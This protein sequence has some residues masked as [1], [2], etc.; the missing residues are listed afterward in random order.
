MRSSVHWIPCFGWVTAI[1]GSRLGVGVKVLQGIK[2]LLGVKWFE[3]V[4]LLLGVKSRGR[5]TPGV[6][7][8]PGYL[9]PGIA[10]TSFGYDVLLVANECS[11][12][13]GNLDIENG[14]L[15][16]DALGTGDSADLTCNNGFQGSTTITVICDEQGIWSN[17]P[18]GSCTGNLC[19]NDIM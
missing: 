14:L 13:D 19:T 9:V 12:A 8:V 6:F 5:F 4:K 2:R 7:A 16:Y 10:V 15:E 11:T 3:Q 18:V 17:K 1:P